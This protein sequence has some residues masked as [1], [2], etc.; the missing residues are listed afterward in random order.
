[1]RCSSVWCAVRTSTRP[2]VSRQPC[3]VMWP[4]SKR[5]ATSASMRTLPRSRRSS[6]S[7]KEE[8]VTRHLVDDENGND[9]DNDDDDD[10]T[11]TSSISSIATASAY[12]RSRSSIMPISDRRR[13]FDS[14]KSTSSSH[15]TGAI[16][17][18][19][20]TFFVHTI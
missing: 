13:P 9:N 16:S 14:S 2:L 20:G 6:M 11:T 7:A 19:I 1:M 10:H 12:P 4:R 5:P 18:N 8:A 17:S 15:Q 3:N